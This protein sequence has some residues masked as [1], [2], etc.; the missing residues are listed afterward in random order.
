[1]KN[2]ILISLMLICLLVGCTKKQSI[3]FEA[4]IESVSEQSILVTIKDNEL[5]FDKASVGIN[6][7]KIDGDLTA[8]KKVN[9]TIQPEVRESYPVQV[10]ATKVEV[11]E[12]IYQKITAEEAK[13]M[14]DNGEYDV[15]LDVRTLEEYNEGHIEGAIVLSHDEVKE[16][17]NTVL[18]NKED[19]VLIYCRSG[20]RS[21]IA[22]KELIAMGY[23]KVYDFGGIIDWQYEVVKE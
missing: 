19:I 21:E 12:A 3:T 16:K 15:L 17:S 6:T 10:T 13:E 23:S 14:I 20:R 11:I 8:G 1:M 18:P 2:I 5:G 7:A 9:I 22:A 4:Q